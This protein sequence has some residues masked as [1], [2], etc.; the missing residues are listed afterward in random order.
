MQTETKMTD[1]ENRGPPPPHSNDA[2]T[3]T[4]TI[5][6][7]REDIEKVDEPQFKAMFETSAEV[8]GSLVKAFKHY[9][10]KNESAWRR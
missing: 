7:P 8:M 3:F 10:Q 4:P 6:H 2:A 9:E 1:A 5:D